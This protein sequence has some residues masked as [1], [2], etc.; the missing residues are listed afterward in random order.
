[1]SQTIPRSVEQ[2]EDLKVQG[3]REKT[4]ATQNFKLTRLPPY[5]FIFKTLSFKT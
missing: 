5:F 1:M 4:K 3:N 2:K